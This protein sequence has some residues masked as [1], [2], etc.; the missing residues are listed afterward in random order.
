MPSSRASARSAG[1]SGPRPAMSSSRPGDLLLRGG[2]RAQEDDV[3]LDRDQPADAEQARRLVRVR[4][5]LAVGRD[6]VVDDLEAL[7][8]EALGLCEVAREPARDRDV[9]VREARDGAVA[10]RERRPSRNS[11]KPCFVEKRTGTRASVPA[12]WP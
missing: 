11:L 10:E 6:P 1:S 3:A 7:L 9:H 8:A 5:R 2:E 4:L 12:I